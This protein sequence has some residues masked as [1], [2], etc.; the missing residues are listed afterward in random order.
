[1]NLKRAFWHHE[2]EV[3]DLECLPW[4][5]KDQL[6]LEILGV[7]FFHSVC[8]LTL[9]QKIP[10]RTLW[11]LFLFPQCRFEGN[12]FFVKFLHFFCT[13]GEE[14]AFWHFFRGCKAI[15]GWY[16]GWYFNLILMHFRCCMPG[17]VTYYRAVGR[18][19]IKE[20]LN[21]G[22]IKFSNV[23]CRNF[24]TLQGRWKMSNKGGPEQG[25]DWIFKYIGTDKG[26]TTII[27]KYRRVEN[28]QS[29]FC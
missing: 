20:G 19:Q 8:Q 10:D 5:I 7:L 2:Q 1:M 22:E 16:V 15:I 13:H 29:A 12:N 14:S 27:L 23:I 4:S 9:L 3:V 26:S 18:C 11:L 17:N 24:D 25:L 6:N 28:S 21:K